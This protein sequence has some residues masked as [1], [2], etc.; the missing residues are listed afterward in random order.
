M[1]PIRQ[2]ISF[3]QKQERTEQNKIAINKALELLNIEENEIKRHFTN[4]F[5]RSKTALLNNVK[6]YSQ[7]YFDNLKDNN[8]QTDFIS[9]EYLDKR[10]PIA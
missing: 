2:M 5:L 8:L 4:G 1:T 10:T 7:V 6:T 9:T 3:L